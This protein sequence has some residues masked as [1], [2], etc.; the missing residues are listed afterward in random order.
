[1]HI[2]WKTCLR[3]G[4]SAFL[5]YL[6]IY[7]WSGVATL[8]G[9]LIQAAFPLVLGGVIACIAHKTLAGEW[10]FLVSCA[11]LIT[12]A[13]FALRMLRNIPVKEQH[14]GDPQ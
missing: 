12:A 5:L 3:V 9:L 1:M 6:A 13:V 11:A 14:R 8:A 4:V 2:E 10:S 7:Y